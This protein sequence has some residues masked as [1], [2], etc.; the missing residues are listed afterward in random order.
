MM[1]HMMI[2][3]KPARCGVE[4]QHSEA[5][6]SET[7]I[8]TYISFFEVLM[9]IPFSFLCLRWGISSLQTSLL[10]TGRRA[11]FHFDNPL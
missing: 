10:Q 3:K 8:A 11:T 6:R 1:M 9:G 4:Q 7:G 2:Q 5:G